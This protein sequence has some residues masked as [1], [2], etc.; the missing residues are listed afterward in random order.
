M[1]ERRTDL[2]SLK[3]RKHRSHFCYCQ[4]LRYG[5]QACLLVWAGSVADTNFVPVGKWALQLASQK[6]DLLAQVRPTV[7]TH[8]AFV[9]PLHYWRSAAYQAV[10]G[11]THE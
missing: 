2:F 1:K 5:H 7:I 10:E 8:Y 9:A 3:N 6:P 11:I 4:P